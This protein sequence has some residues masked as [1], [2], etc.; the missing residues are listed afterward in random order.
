[1][2]QCG[3][4]A[5]LAPAPGQEP[6]AMLPAL[7]KMLRSIRRMRDATSTPEQ[8]ESAGPGVAGAAQLNGAPRPCALHTPAA[9]LRCSQPFG[10][11]LLACMPAPRGA[12][13]P[14]P[15][16][17]P[18]QPGA[19][20]GAD[21]EVVEAAA[22]ADERL[23]AMADLGVAVAKALA[24]R[25]AGGADKISEE[26][27]GEV[28]MPGSLYRM[29]AAGAIGKCGAVLVTRGTGGQGHG[30]WLQHGPARLGQARPGSSPASRAWAH[31]HLPER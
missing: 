6:L 5:L 15:R 18:E 16:H 27:P 21:P 12:P 17:L 4:E 14:R 25:Q 10:W 8:D 9:C 3:L 31:L 23:W 13:L 28:S 11:V 24:R 7:L 19:G 29:P 1:M 2:M 20:A 26:Y 22:A 30:Y